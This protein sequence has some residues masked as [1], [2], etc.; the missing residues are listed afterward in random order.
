MKFLVGYKKMM[1]S[2]PEETRARLDRI[3]RTPPTAM[4]ELPPQYQAALWAS[5]AASSMAFIHRAP[6]QMAPTMITAATMV[7]RVQN[8]AVSNSRFAPEA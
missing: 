3:I 8:T 5:R 1:K 6:P 2:T 4:P 7:A